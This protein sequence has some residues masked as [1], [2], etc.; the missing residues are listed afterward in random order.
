LAGSPAR[1]P[2]ARRPRSGSARPGSGCAPGQ[3]RMGQRVAGPGVAAG[4]GRADLCCTPQRGPSR[5]LVRDRSRLCLGPCSGCRPVIRSFRCAWLV[6]VPNRPTAAWRR[7]RRYA[8]RTEAFTPSARAI[9]EPEQECRRSR[10]CSPI[11]P[12]I[13]PDCRELERAVPMTL[14]LDALSG[15]ELF[16]RVLAEERPLWIADQ[17][18]LRRRQRSRAAGE[19]V[20]R[21][22]IRD[23]SV[24]C[25]RAGWPG[26]AAQGGSVVFARSVPGG[27]CCGRFR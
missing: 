26:C 20:G 22:P 8:Q 4:T 7:R 2:G 9:P 15:D 18:L 16:T 12:M 24:R 6:T 13:G 23:D 11:S 5:V 3:P 1:R 17:P 21:R 10:G 19:Q 14:K 27:S 25:R